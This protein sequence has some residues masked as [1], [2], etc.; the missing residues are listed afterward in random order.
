VHIRTAGFGLNRQSRAKVAEYLAIRPRDLRCSGLI[1]RCAL[2]LLAT[3][4][5]DLVAI[6]MFRL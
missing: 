4:L 5:P 2:D 6:A 1:I 3:R